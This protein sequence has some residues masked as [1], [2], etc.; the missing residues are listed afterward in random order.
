MG[1]RLSV[2]AFQWLAYS[3][4]TRNDITHAGNGGGSFAWVTK[5]ESQLV[6]RRDEGSL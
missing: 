5:C 1:D 6:L 3:G 4:Q 2:E